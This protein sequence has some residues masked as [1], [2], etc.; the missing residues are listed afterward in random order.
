MLFDSPHANGSDD[1]ES[2]RRLGSVFAELWQEW[3]ETVSE[4]ALETH[5]MCEYISRSRAFDKDAYGPFGQFAQFG[6]VSGEPIDIDKLK[7]CLQSMDPAQATRVL[8]AV[9]AMHAMEAM[10]ERYRAREREHH[11]SSR[12]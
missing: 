3:F 1:R 12:W 4:L 10:L 2:R 7:Q 8:Y 5:Q 9:Q 11:E 6:G